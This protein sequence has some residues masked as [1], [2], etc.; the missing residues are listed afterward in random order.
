MSLWYNGMDLGEV[1]SWEEAERLL[2]NTFG[3]WNPDDVEMGE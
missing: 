3:Y 1:S 2:T